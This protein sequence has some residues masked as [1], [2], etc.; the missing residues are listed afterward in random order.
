MILVVTISKDF[1]LSIYKGTNVSQNDY[2]KKGSICHTLFW[3]LSVSAGA[4]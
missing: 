4:I 3:Q 1:Y 2:V